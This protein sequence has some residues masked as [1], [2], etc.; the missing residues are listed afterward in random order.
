MWDPFSTWP[1]IVIEFKL[2]ILDREDYFI[3]QAWDSGVYNNGSIRYD[4]KTRLRQFMYQFALGI[5]R[6]RA[7]EVAVVGAIKLQE[8]QAIYLPEDMRTRILRRL[9]MNGVSPPIGNTWE[10][11]LVSY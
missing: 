11:M 9:Q 3:N 6:V 7:H 2:S 10:Q 5:E 4:E 1:K 8:F